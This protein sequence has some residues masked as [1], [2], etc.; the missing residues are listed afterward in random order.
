MVQFVDVEDRVEYIDICCC[1]VRFD[2]VMRR[3]CWIEVQRGN[4][5]CRSTSFFECRSADSRPLFTSVRC[6]SPC[7]AC[8]TCSHRSVV[9]CRSC[10]KPKEVSCI[11]PTNKAKERRCKMKMSSERR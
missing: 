1:V 7:L 11:T 8:S 9:F 4:S 2:I 3:R 5:T 10:T 6:C